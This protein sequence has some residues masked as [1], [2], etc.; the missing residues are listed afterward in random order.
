[1]PLYIIL[2]LLS[3]HANYVKEK[4]KLRNEVSVISTH[5]VEI[6]H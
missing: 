4:R 5:N 6:K 3:V 2:K 1:M